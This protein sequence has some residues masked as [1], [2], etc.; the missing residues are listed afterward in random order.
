MMKN[1]A[2]LLLFIS[3]F[4]F[5]VTTK[6]Q[7]TTQHHI[8]PSPWQYWSSANEIVITTLEPGIVNA[9]ISKSDGTQII[10]LALTATIPA[11][12]RFEGVPMQTPRNNFNTLYNDRGIIVDSDA[13][14]A[15]NVRNIASDDA[16]T[17]GDD[18]GNFI[19]G[20]ASL[21]SFGDQGKGTSFWLGYYRRDY[22]GLSGSAPV[23]SVMAIENGT[24]VLL[25]N[26]ALV[27]LNAGQSYLFTAPMG[28]LLSTN[29]P[30]VANSG[31]YSDAPGSCADGVGTQIIPTQSLGKNYVI[32]RGN[33]T[34]GTLPVY[35][36]QS[37]IIASQPN[38]V[39][40][41]T[42]YTA[43]GVFINTT[44]Q[45]IAT[46]GGS[47]T[48]HHGDARTQYSSSFVA[49]DK[50]VIIY[51]GSAD[52]CE[53][54]MSTVIPVGDCTG[55]NEIIT[56]KYTAYNGNDLSAFGYII[57]ASATEPVLFNGT[58]LETLTGNTRTQ[59]GTTGYYIMNFTNSQVG[60]PENYHITSAAKMTVSIVQSGDGFSMSGF[61]SAF[62]STVTTPQIASTQNCSTVIT[63]TPGL[64]PYQWYLDGAPI[65]GAID[66]DLTVA[67][68]GN[69]SVTGTLDC[70]ITA[71]SSPLFIQVCS[72]LSV[73]KT[74]DNTTNTGN[75]TFVITANNLGA[76]QDTN[77]KVTDVLPNGYTFVSATADA[78]TYS[79]TTGIW[80]IG[81]L[82]VNQEVILRV[83][84]SLNGVG[85]LTNTAT[86]A[87]AN[88]DVNQANNTATAT[89]YWAMTFTKAAQQAVYHNQGDVVIYNLILT[90]TGNVTIYDINT[91]DANADA[92]SVIP[93]FIPAL[94]VGQ[95]VTLTASHTVTAADVLAG[96]VINQATAVG[97]S[98]TDVFIRT[99]SDDPSTA[100]PN[101][102]T[103]VA[104]TSQADLV[105]V[106]TDNS[107]IYVAGN[108]VVYTITVVNNGP[109]NAVNVTIQ[110]ALPPG[111]TVMDW[112]SS[113]GT[114][115]TGALSEIVPLFLNGGAVTYTVTIAVPA[116]YTGNLTN[117]A[118]VTS[119][120]FD[121]DTTCTQCTDIDLPF[122][123]PKAD[124]VTVKT[125]NQNY[126]L[127]GS[128]VVYTITVTN[129]GPDDAANVTVQDALP[130]GITVMNWT[131]SLG[132]T[133]S[134]ALTDTTP[135]L[136]NGA[137]IVYTVTIA[138][139]DD[140]TGNLTN[141]AVVNSDTFDPD[142]TC[143]QCTDV[144]LETIIPKADL[145]TIKT[146]NKEYYVAGNNVVYTI[147]VTNN[148]P[149]DAANVTVQD[150][151]PQ[152]ILVMNWTSS[153]GTSGS[154]S[155]FET[156]PLLLNG[157]S[158]IYTVTVAVPAN[159][160]GNLTNTAV[161]NSDT[162]D[163]DA[164]C[165]NCTDIDLPCTSPNPDCVIEN[166]IIP[167]G[168][169]P[170][171]DD[172][173]DFFD[174][175]KLPPIAK[176]EIFNRYGLSVYE[177]SNYI[178][179]WNGKTNSGDELPTGTYFYVIH[180]KEKKAETGWVYINR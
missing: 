145:V 179:E 41:I 125:D 79:N 15:V 40:Q 135:L 99:N 113:L 63:T 19:K 51:S 1:Y 14:V 95:S 56:H 116:A 17:A 12:Y 58:D 162:L 157:E 138:V 118:V 126:Y 140:Y 30:V 147:T 28:S 102:A 172:K 81:T 169:S 11:V 54:D 158:L 20:N 39:V 69:Y 73:T 31:A 101:D 32:V 16:N 60:N 96:E 132:T 52:F 84:A 150:D 153:L 53:V 57:L 100:L 45:T 103:V 76:F 134:G 106:K 10:T 7:T 143:A 164:T 152:G 163:P 42:N 13:P 117:T 104:V 8:A 6:A 144:D 82:N 154:G 160:I 64:E 120:T 83:V 47:Y 46:A 94:A 44:T 128:N 112:T 165:A 48:F 139:P 68:S 43:Q 119:D 72:D 105:T 142:T 171:V 77:V 23:F 21:V 129:N 86:I 74:I 168:I 29:K 4:L 151:L 155:L 9:T 167:K 50:P 26:V 146:D 137:S 5:S 78:G 115:G 61:F 123:A 173:N 156:V 91:V 2:V 89:P 27:T 176:L 93:S 130:Q 178:K 65:A 59:I 49:A 175:S 121:P 22:T 35:P 107:N 97:E 88:L 124:L 170:Y 71:Q 159:F 136:A 37:T 80:T 92:G 149:D 127:A 3:A 62:N 33:G 109:G 111:I 25:N 122:I 180:F 18:A 166:Y 148:G 90:N 133:G 141:T 55:S 131:N 98:F 161:V 38:T 36:E 75:I 108:N 174:L 70:G 87:G 24:Q 66:Q 85:N 34:I 110:D 177:R 67:N 114:S